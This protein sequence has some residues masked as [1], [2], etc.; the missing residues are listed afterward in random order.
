MKGVPSM[1]KII[2]L[3]VFAILLFLSACTPSV[4]NEKEQYHNI[5]L[6]PEKI[7]STSYN[8]ISIFEGNLKNTK[9]CK[10]EQIN[11]SIEKNVW[12]I[13]GKEYI[14]YQTVETSIKNS[15]RWKMDF[16]KMI[17]CCK[18]QDFI[19][20][21]N[22]GKSDNDVLLVEY[23]NVFFM[24]VHKDILNPFNYKT[25]DFVIEWYKSDYDLIT[26][27]DVEEVWQSHLDNKND[28]NAVASEERYPIIRLRLIEHP[29]LIYTFPF[30]K[31]ND[32]ICSPP[33]FGTNHG[34][35]GDGSMID[36]NVK[37]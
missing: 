23:S 15:A 8:Q 22:D 33:V 3:F 7:I 21:S 12:K 31:I 18:N 35:S 5:L 37:K 32:E 28:I 1:K 36:I 11:V 13:N 27:T 9:D 25:E 10:S 30:I 16:S 26:N 14:S 19:I 2:P 17:P 20:Y 34:Q 24:L 4:I 29:E 6:E